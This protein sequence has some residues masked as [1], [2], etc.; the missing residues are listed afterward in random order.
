MWLDKK[1]ISQPTSGHALIHKYISHFCGHGWY[2]GH[3]LITSTWVGCILDDV[4][5]PYVSMNNSIL[6]ITSYFHI[7]MV[8]HPGSNNHLQ[9]RNLIHGN[10]LFLSSKKQQNGKVSINNGILGVYYKV[11]INMLMKHL[12][13]SI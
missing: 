12:Y 4:Q 3:W 1:M 13:I 5:A 2:H 8:V 7:S 9:I 11:T 10:M 6:F